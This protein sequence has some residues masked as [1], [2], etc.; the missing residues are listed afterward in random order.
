MKWCV[1]RNVNISVACDNE[2]PTVELRLENCTHSH[3]EDSSPMLLIL[4]GIGTVILILGGV[5]AEVLVYCLRKASLSDTTDNEHATSN[6]TSANQEVIFYR[7]RP[8]NTQEQNN[9]NYCKITLPRN[10]SDVHLSLKS[11]ELTT[12]Q[13]PHDMGRCSNLGTVNEVTM[14]T[15]STTTYAEPFQYT[16][17]ASEIYAVPY[18]EPTPNKK[19]S[20]IS[21]E[22]MLLSES[23]ND[24]PPPEIS[25]RNSLYSSS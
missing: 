12:Q 9:S 25:V 20:E 4:A 2:S 6:E 11:E 18:Q 7:I 8:N 19:D 17:K 15:D 5:L 22:N 14:A 10:E 23:N 24:I 3:V 1:K 16:A 13:S 21:Y